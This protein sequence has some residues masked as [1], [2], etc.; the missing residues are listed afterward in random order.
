MQEH[1]HTEG[2]IDMSVTHPTT[3]A[4]WASALDGQGRRQVVRRVARTSD[5]RSAACDLISL[6]RATGEAVGV[7]LARDEI[8]A[9]HG[10]S[11]NVL[12]SADGEWIATW[13]NQDGYWVGE[14]YELPAS[15]R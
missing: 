8:H 14:H 3:P 4:E 2:E 5:L 11:D 13:C 15:T 6:A 12:L 7:S 9:L 10:L 1:D